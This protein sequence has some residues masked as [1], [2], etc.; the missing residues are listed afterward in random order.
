MVLCSGK[1]YYELHEQREKLGLQDKVALVR[2]EQVRA[3]R[4]MWRAGGCWRCA[5]CA[6]CTIP[7]LARWPRLGSRLLC[8]ALHRLCPLRAACQCLRQVLHTNHM[9]HTASPTLR[10]PSTR[11]TLLHPHLPTPQLAPFPFDLL[12]REVR[13]YPNAEFLWCQEEPMNMGAFMHVQPRIDSCLRAEGRSSTGRI[14][15][16]GRPPSASTATG[17]GSVHAQVGDGAAVAAALWRG[18]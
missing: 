12:C 2:V 6:A 14:P 3:R 18:W 13:R 11:L 17:F 5:A 4:L 9:L 1:V 7:R 8:S 10:T 16:A 15:Y